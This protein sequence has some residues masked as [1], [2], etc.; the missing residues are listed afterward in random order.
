MYK[1]DA[2][3]YPWVLIEVLIPTCHLAFLDFHTL[4]RVQDQKSSVA[5]NVAYIAS[6]ADEVRF[7]ELLLLYPPLHVPVAFSEVR[8]RLA[9][10]LSPKNGR[11]LFLGKNG[12]VNNRET[13]CALSTP[14]GSNGIM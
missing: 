2:R 7:H 8:L 4:E 13:F 11:P 9:P 3:I 14:F 12:L 1:L 5:Q 6:M 10:S